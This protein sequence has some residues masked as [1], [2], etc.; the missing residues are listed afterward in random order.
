MNPKIFQTLLLE[1]YRN[2]KNYGTMENPT[3]KYK[4]SNPLCGDIIEIYLKI[5]NEKIVDIKFNGQGCAISQA[6]ASMLT[7][8]IKNKSVNYAKNF[9]KEDMLSLF[10]NI[11]F[12]PTRIKCALL[13]FKVFKMAIYSYLQN[14]GA[15]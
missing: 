10:K 6:G 13:P 4:D 1:H 15:K 5:E 12:G 14:K 2:P 11:D 9:S 3:V 7:E 8:Q